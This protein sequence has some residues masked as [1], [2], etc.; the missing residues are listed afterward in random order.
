MMDGRKD[1]RTNGQNDGLKKGRTDGRMNRE[2][3]HGW[4]DEQTE[5]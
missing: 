2:S 4:K 1:E 5:E 3:T